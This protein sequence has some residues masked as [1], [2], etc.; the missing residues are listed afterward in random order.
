VDDHELVFAHLVA[1]PPVV[2]LDNLTRDRID[3]LLS[4]AVPRLEIDLPKGDFL[5][6]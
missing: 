2:P 4:E 6:C 1:A 3:Q 5:G